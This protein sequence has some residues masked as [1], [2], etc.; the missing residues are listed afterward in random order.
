[1]YRYMQY[2]FRVYLSDVSVNAEQEL[3]T[4]TAYPEMVSILYIEKS[5]AE[6]IKPLRNPTS[7][8][9]IIG[10]SKVWYTEEHIKQ[11]AMHLTAASSIDVENIV[12]FDTFSLSP[13]NVHVTVPIDALFDAQ[14]SLLGGNSPRHEVH[15]LL[16]F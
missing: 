9:N 1:M 10:I 15:C 14:Q 13:C 4:A 12:V 5:G 6:D 3:R 11:N 16:P 2:E 8:E 7:D